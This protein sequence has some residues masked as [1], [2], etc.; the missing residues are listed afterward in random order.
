MKKLVK[1]KKLLSGEGVVDVKI[2]KQEDID[3]A[4]TA[5]K[6]FEPGLEKVSVAFKDMYL[7]EYPEMHIEQLRSA[8]KFLSTDYQ[9]GFLASTIVPQ[10]T[11]TASF[12]EQWRRLIWTEYKTDKDLIVSLQKELSVLKEKIKRKRKRT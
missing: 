7:N 1:K 3:G 12:F 6:E 2:L 11:G 10:L 8:A 5:H 9:S 4:V